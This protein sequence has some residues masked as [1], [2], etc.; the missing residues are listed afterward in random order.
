MTAQ[1][2]QS[3]EEQHEMPE[4]PEKHVDPLCEVPTF[5][6]IVGQSVAT[7]PTPPTLT[8]V[9]SDCEP[10]CPGVC[11]PWGLVARKWHDMSVPYKVLFSFVSR[12]ISGH[13]EN[14]MQPMKNVMA[15]VSLI[16]VN[17]YDRI[18]F[19]MVRSSCYNSGRPI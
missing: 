19:T 4:Q 6:I 17:S 12:S 14:S 2:Q 8:R 9:T 18:I 16:K 3:Q 7:P 11:R 10:V 1:S 13:C 5:C 15:F